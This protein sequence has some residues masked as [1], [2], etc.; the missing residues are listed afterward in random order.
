MEEPARELLFDVHKALLRASEPTRIVSRLILFALVLLHL[1][2]TFSSLKWNLAMIA[3]GVLV[4]AYWFLNEFAVRRNID[5]LEERIAETYTI[6]LAQLQKS[7]ES[8]SL[9]QV[10]AP[11]GD[12]EPKPTEG[13]TQ[14]D[15]SLIKRVEET[16]INTYINWRHERW[17]FANFEVAQM[18]EPVAW[19]ILLLVLSIS[20]VL[21]R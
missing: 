2:L 5:R 11:A 3:T 13:N 14:N 17:K 8:I 6:R 16:W 20:K 7:Q 18:L 15:E 19:F 4:A 10:D 21:A 9:P 1:V 12:A